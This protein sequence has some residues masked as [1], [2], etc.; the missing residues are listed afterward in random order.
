MKHLEQLQNEYSIFFEKSYPPSGRRQQLTTPVL[1]VSVSSGG[2]DLHFKAKL[3]F[4]LPVPL[5]GPET[6]GI[7]TNAPKLIITATNMVCEKPILEIIHMT[8]V[9]EKHSAQKIIL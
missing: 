2:R 4:N 5:L 9:G 3:F 7:E 6:F 1:F 8:L